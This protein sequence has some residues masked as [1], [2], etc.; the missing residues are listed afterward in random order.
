MNNL[1]FHS[2]VIVLF[3]LLT[4]SIPCC[5][6]AQTDVIKDSTSNFQ[7]KI[8]RGVL[9]LIGGGG[10]T[11]SQMLGVNVCFQKDNI[12]YGLRY[13]Y[14]TDEK[15]INLSEYSLPYEK[16]LEFGI[17][18]GRKR[19]WTKNF[20]GTLGGGM[21]YVYGVKRGDYLYTKNFFFSDISYYEQ[22]KFKSIG[23]TADARINFILNKYINLSIN[24]VVNLNY[25]R[26]FY[27]ILLGIGFYIPY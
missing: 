19:K 11:S 7:K 15:F 16:S 10:S 8:E 3:V 22:K 14:N 17:Y 1:S 24:G 18:Y 20:N 27:G 21:S 9:G 13:I 25:Y 5:L 26:S 4:L 6:N 23:F 2:F 12:I